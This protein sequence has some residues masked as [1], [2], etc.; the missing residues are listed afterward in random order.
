M[1]RREG[2]GFYHVCTNGTVL[3]WMFKCEEDFIG[4]INRI[5]VCK[6][7][8]GVE[9]W[10]FTLMD[11]HGHFLLYGTYEICKL[12]IDR[13]KFLTG[14]WI[15]HFHNQSRHIKSLPVSIIPLKSEEDLLETIAY[16]DRN[17]MLAGFSELPFKYPW[18]STRLIFS[19]LKDRTKDSVGCRIK[20][21][22]GNQ[23]RDI[24]KTRVSLPD[25]WVIDDKGMLDPACFTEWE[26]VEKLY[27]SPA[28]YL[29]YLT[30]K[31]EGKI[32]L[33]LSEGTKTFVSD[34]DLRTITEGV[35]LE[36]FGSDNIRTL[37]VKSRLTIARILKRDYA[38]T[39]KQLSRM[40]HL[41]FD[42]LKGFV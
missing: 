37:D 34:K 15:S 19:G 8:S 21:F 29:Y 41:D 26:K 32:N 40:L 13:Y 30:K 17:A 33:A 25:D 10:A 3:P 42:V 38:S 31:L 24:L 2:L 28:R 22:T 16:I 11:N 9:V 6:V 39:A 20:D 27:K 5:G 12:F 35:A 7:I 1:E 4:G 36:M 14:M 23:L 18:A